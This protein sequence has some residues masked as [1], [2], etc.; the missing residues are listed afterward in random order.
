[1]P[2]PP[3]HTDVLVVGGG[4]VGLALSLALRHHGVDHLVVE[5]TDGTVGHPKVGTVGPRSMELFRRWG[6]AP[7][8]REAGWPDDHP[9]DVAWV[10]A[11]GGH[12]ILRLPFGTAAGRPLPD[13]TP[14]PDQVCPQHWL[15]PALLTALGT[16]P[17]GPV[18][19]GLRCDGTV[20]HDDR[21]TATVTDETGGTS[22]TVDAAYVVA[23]DGAASPLR[24]ACGVP[25]PSYHRTRV[26]RNIL[27]DAPELRDRLGESAALVHFL[28]ALGLLRYPLRAMDGRAMYRLT[29]SAESEAERAEDAL[30]LLRRAVAFDTPLTVLSDNT[31]HLTHRVA[32]SFRAG[33]VFFAG[34]AAH[35]LSPSGGFGMNTG[36]ADADNLA[37]KLAA[38]LAGWAGPGLLDSYDTERRPVA[39]HS[40]DEAHANMARTTRRTLPPEIASDTAEGARARAELARRME[41]GGVRREF[42]APDMAFGLRY[43]SPLIMNGDAGRDGADGAPDWRQG[44]VPGVRA[45]H[46]WLAPDRS[47]LDLF[48]RRYVLLTF[49]PTEPAVEV[50]RAF[51]DHR[52]P[53]TVTPCADPDV[54]RR[55]GKP[56]VLVRPDG[57]VAWCGTELPADTDAFVQRLRGAAPAAAPL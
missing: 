31:W 17:H 34:D 23:C 26:F 2:R 3:L 22:T 42:D 4:P 5:R 7:A 18:R 57:H 10:T 47:T 16:H 24:K 11:V 9:L 35:T 54:A 46:A 41:Q 12:E 29:A 19:L 52:V 50:R 27:F 14:E 39:E 43:D 48:G 33:R 25:A 32:Q 51:A 6:V 28:T 30:G 40:L 38:R 56:L 37:W 45:P 44:A 1:M 8:L 13:H 21:V 55:Y 20:R 15:M 53:L 49:D 36:I